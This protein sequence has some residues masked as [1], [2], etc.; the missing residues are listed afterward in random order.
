M[1]VEVKILNELLSY[2]TTKLRELAKKHNIPNY[3]SMIREDLINNLCVKLAEEQGKLYAFGTL[4]ILND[5][6]GFL[7][8]TGLDA[9]V[10]VSISQIR[11]IALRQGDIICGEIRVPIG[12]EKNYGL[13]KIEFINSDTIDKALNRPIF[14]ELIPSYPNE[15]INL[16]EGEVSSRL[17]DLISPIGKGQRGLIVA[18]PKGG[19]TVLLT[20][21]ANDIIKYNKDIDVWILLIDERP[22]EVTD[23]KE[24]VK[25]AEV[26]S[27][28]FDED[29]SIHIKVTEKVLEAAKIE[30]EKG[31]NILILMDS[32]TRL[33]RSYNVVIPSSGK[34]ISGGI[35]PKALYMPKKFLGAARNIRNGGSLTIIATALIETG[36]RM[37]E[38]I[39]EEFK[40]TGNMEIILD[41]TLQQLRLFPAI[42]ILKSGTR[43]EELLYSKSELE[44][45]W[46][47][48]KKL[49]KCNEAEAL[50]YMLD[51]IKKYPTNKE[52]IDNIKYDLM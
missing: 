37:D 3:K 29:P 32:L 28:T 22:E 19:K 26:Y 6:Y 16:G 50:K 11:K 17:I 41:R 27:A 25:E 4:D 47:L 18:P 42:D 35:D 20:T 7:R 8:N 40:G 49:M 45:I 31:K 48:R 34:I 14:D 5:G 52:L 44:A 10:Y 33:A 15:R 24:T 9:D 38:V 23:I 43:K 46:S 13:I 51:L 21:L 12:T 2:K 39:F 30:V 1:K 36:S